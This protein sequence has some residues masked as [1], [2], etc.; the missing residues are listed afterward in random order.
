MVQMRDYKIFFY[1]IYRFVRRFEPSIPEWGTT[2]ALYALMLFNVGSL[3]LAIYRF[4]N[5]PLISISIFLMLMFLI[6][7]V[8]YFVFIYNKKYGGIIKYIEKR[9][10]EPRLRKS[11]I[12]LL[13][14]AF[15]SLLVFFINIYSY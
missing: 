1:L 4:F 10:T 9:I 15:L 8:H 5:I 13:I 7:I 2:L 6:W 3:M 14:Y 12:Y 11:K